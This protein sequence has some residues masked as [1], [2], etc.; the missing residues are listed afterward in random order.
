MHQLKQSQI[1]TMLY[2]S[3]D[4]QEIHCET[5]AGEIGSTAQVVINID[6]SQVVSPHSVMFNYRNNPSVTS[7]FPGNTIHSGGI[8]LTFSG[9]DMDVIQKPILETKLADGNISVSI[10]CSR[11]L[12]EWGQFAVNYSYLQAK[13]CTAVNGSIITCI[14]PN[15]G[16]TVS[17]ILNYSLI[18][19]AVPPITSAQIHISIHPDPSNF[20]LATKWSTDLGTIIGISVRFTLQNFIRCIQLLAWF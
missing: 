6:S 12:T 1:M 5:T 13:G 18:L 15:L 17:N 20:S 8:T 11:I 9:L 14:T 4:A 3:I 10:Y 2:S 7:V 16:T 19:D